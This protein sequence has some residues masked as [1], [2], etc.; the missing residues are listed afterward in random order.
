MIGAQTS[1]RAE[2]GLGT[3]LELR[4]RLSLATPLDTVRGMSF[5]T[6]LD[7]LRL[8]L[9]E[10]A[11]AQC[12]EPLKEKSYKSFFTYPVSEYLRLLYSA[13]WLLSEK[14]GG[15]DHAVRRIGAGLAPG[16]LGSVVGKAFMLLAKEGPRQLLANM[17]VAHRAA[18]SFGEAT[19]HWA[20]PRS[21]V[22]TIKR[23]FLPYLCHEGGLLG[24]FRTLGLQ[25]GRVSGRQIGPLDNEVEFSWG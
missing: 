21:G 23:D 5:H 16:F 8:D 22:L 2:S 17:P 1:T 24:L 14:H 18:A 20:G 15:F 9:G 7:V 13:A 10:E 3:E 4:R 19:V 25:D 6:T 11:L 12:L